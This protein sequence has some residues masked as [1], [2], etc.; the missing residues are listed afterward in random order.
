MIE[1]RPAVHTDVP[2]LAALM[3]ELGYPS[4]P[5]E[6]AVRLKAINDRGSMACLIA[7][8]DGSAAGMIGLA[9]TPSFARNPPHGEIAALVVSEGSR[10]R[11]VGRALVARGEEW[12]AARGVVR[13]TVN[14]GTH[15][16]RAHAFYRTCGYEQ[17]GFRFVRE[18]A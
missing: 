10:R 17:N 11:G 15:R 14:S 1:I 13:A 8:H 5:A 2:G 3:T 6:M 18:L 16:D 4:T 12:L 9:V 7:F